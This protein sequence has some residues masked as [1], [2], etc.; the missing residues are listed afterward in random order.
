MVVAAVLLVEV[1]VE[2][3]VEVFS[4]PHETSKTKTNLFQSFVFG[5]LFGR[6]ILF[7]MERGVLIV[8]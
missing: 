7:S 8:Q 1:E 6:A 3:E 5:T 2:M 4:E